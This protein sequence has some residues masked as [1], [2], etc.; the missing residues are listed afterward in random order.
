MLS[1]HIP[2]FF[3]ALSPKACDASFARARGFFER[4]FPDESYEIAVCHSWLLD[5]QLATY[6]SPESNIVQ[7]AQRFTPTHTPDPNNNDTLLFVFG[8]TQEYLDTLPQ[9]TR[10]ERIVVE[11]I[12]AGKTWHG[13]AGWMRLP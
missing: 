4:H 13:G 11:H 9:N 5:P 6:L 12:R 2:A 1:V 8:K 7:F 3:G 10:I